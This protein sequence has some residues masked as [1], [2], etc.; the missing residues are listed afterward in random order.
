ME[1][2]LLTDYRGALRQKVQEWESLD[3]AILTRRLEEAGFDVGV[4]RIEDAA[5]GRFVPEGATIVYTSTQVPGYRPLVDDVLYTLSRRNRLVP[6]YEIFRAHENKGFQELLKRELGLPSLRW[7][8]YG[9]LKGLERD[10]DEGTLGLDFPLVLKSNAGFQSRGVRRIEDPDRLRAAVRAMNRPRGL[11]VYRLKQILKRRVLRERYFPE[12]YEDCVHAGPFVLQ[13]FV[14]GAAGDWK[15]LVFADRVFVLRRAIRPGDFRASGSG[16]FSYETP[17]D[18]VLDFAHEVFRRLDVPFVSL[19]VI[20]GE[21]A[22]HLVEFQ[23]VHFGTYTL[24]R[25]PFHFRRDASGWRRHDGPANLEAEYARA[26]ARHV[27]P[28]ASGAPAPGDPSIT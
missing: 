22:C 11:A 26:L 17:P 20:E 2:I 19:D 5:N 28:H 9:N 8:Y 6:R 1:L 18:A 3:T 16:R 27:R 7:R 25:A 14:P 10:L 24:D 13:E 23:G 4:R 12:M 15:V 21:G